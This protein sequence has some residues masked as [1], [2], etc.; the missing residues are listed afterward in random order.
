MRALQPLVRD[1]CLAEM[2]GL[3]VL[4]RFI[5]AERRAF[6]WEEDRISLTLTRRSSGREKLHSSS[7]IQNLYQPSGSRAG[8]GLRGSSDQLMAVMIA[9]YQS[10]YDMGTSFVERREEQVKVKDK[11]LKYS[12]DARRRVERVGLNR[13]RVSVTAYLLG[14]W[15][16][17]VLVLHANKIKI[18]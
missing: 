18:Q 10:S 12:N 16:T 1:G 13:S 8:S 4:V 2:L 17:K 5:E 15:Y 6:V 3:G 9:K 14:L 7:S 11:P